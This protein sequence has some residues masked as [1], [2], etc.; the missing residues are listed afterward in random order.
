MKQTT[1]KEEFSLSG[2]GLHLGEESKVTVKPAPA[3]TGYKFISGKDE[4]LVRPW[5]IDGSKHRAILT[6]N[7]GTQINTVEHIL[8]ALYGMGVDNALVEVEGKEIPGLDG[9]AL[10]FARKI[11]QLGIVELAEEADFYQLQKEATAGAYGCSITITGIKEPE[12]QISYLIDYKESSLAQGLVE[13]VITPEVFL[14]EIAP[15]RTFVMQSEVERLQKAGYG[16]GADTQNTLVLDGDKVVNNSFRVEN[17][18]AAHKILDIIGDLACIGTRLG[19]HIFACKSGHLLNNKLA[20]SLCLD[21]LE[22]KHPGGVMDIKDIKQKLPHRYPFQLVD[23]VIEREEAKHIIAY[24]NL[25]SN[26]EF[27]CGHFPGQPIMPG[28]LQIEALAQAGGLGMSISDED[29]KLA[30]LTG[31]DNVKFRRQVVPGDKLLLELR[32]VKYNGRIGS[33]EGRATVDNELA[34][35]ATIKFAFIERAETEN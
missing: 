22:Q 21:A 28:V 34:C 18:T 27:F 4:G 33:V 17:E 23:R 26:E 14:K 20:Y 12:L 25:T 5:R 7:K 35:S 15:A 29:G 31:V 2:V 3:G 9:S 32:V 6:L 24:K 11:D 8:A 16:K 13:K 30:V 19:G 10:E 1:L